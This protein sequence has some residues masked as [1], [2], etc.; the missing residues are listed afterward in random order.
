MTDTVQPGDTIIPVNAPVAFR[1]KLTV[2]IER[3]DLVGR[4]EAGLWE[5]EPARYATYSSD[6]VVTL[7]SADE[8]S[9]I[10]LALAEGSGKTVERLREETRR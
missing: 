1:Y 6:G 9:A 10:G 3:C 7:P 2:E 5:G 8:L 4:K